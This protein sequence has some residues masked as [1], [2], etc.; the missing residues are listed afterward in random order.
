MMNPVERIARLTG[1]RPW[2]VVT[3]AILLL[4]GTGILAKRAYDSAIVSHAVT[5]ANNRTLQKQVEANEAGADERLQDQQ[6]ISE[7]EKGFSDAI[8][9]PRPCDPP[10]PAVRLA[11]QRLRNAG[12]GETS[13]PI[14]CLCPATGGG[15]TQS[16]P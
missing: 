16:D 12:Y 6:I 11:C 3:A 15:Q 9:N 13:L 7:I 4:V 8:H 5:Q 2:V 10:D 1:F 14:P